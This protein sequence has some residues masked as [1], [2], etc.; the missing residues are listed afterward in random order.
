[1]IDNMR[2][3]YAADPVLPILTGR[4]ISSPGKKGKAD[5]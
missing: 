2:R 5:E 4:Q 1:M 3:E